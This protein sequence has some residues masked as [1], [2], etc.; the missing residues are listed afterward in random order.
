LPIH[1]A[2]EGQP[3]EWQNSGD[4][5]TFWQDVSWFPDRLQPRQWFG[6]TLH[7]RGD[8]IRGRCAVERATSGRHLLHVGAKR[9]QVSSR[10]GVFP[11]ELPR[12][13]A[14]GHAENGALRRQVTGTVG[15]RPRASAARACG[16][17]DKPKWSSF[18]PAF[19][20][21]TLPGFKSRWTIPAR[22]AA[23]IVSAISMRTLARMGPCCYSVF[24]VKLIT[25]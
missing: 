10:I 9:K 21:M 20:I 14:P 7:G 1:E 4:D 16:V 2:A 23:S 6:L 12:R 13:H 19:M 22:C 18:A 11:F 25:T 3:A 17:F 8:H 15:K 5:D 24:V